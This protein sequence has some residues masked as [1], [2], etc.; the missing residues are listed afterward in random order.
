[1]TAF[2]WSIQIPTL[3]FIAPRETVSL[4]AP[5]RQDKGEPALLRSV[6]DVCLRN[7]NPRNLHKPGQVRPGFQQRRGYE[8]RSGIPKHLGALVRQRRRS[9]AP[10]ENS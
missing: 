9:P 8:R 5:I 1:M 3:W 4:P 7:G 2:L 6:R 10:D